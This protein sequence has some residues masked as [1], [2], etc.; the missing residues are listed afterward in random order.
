MKSLNKICATADWNGPELSEMMQ[1]I[2]QPGIRKAADMTGRYGKA[3]AMK[4]ES[5]RA[6]ITCKSRAF[7]R[8]E[9][10]RIRN[11]IFCFENKTEIYRVIPTVN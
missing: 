10:Q 6:H 9:L 7:L 8:L 11:L 1:E 3:L 4:K 5:L 2:L